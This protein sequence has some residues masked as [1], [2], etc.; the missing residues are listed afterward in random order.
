MLTFADQFAIAALGHPTRSCEMRV[1]NAAATL[2]ITLWIEIEED[3]NRF[4][5]VGAIARCVEQAHIELHVFSI[6][7]CQRL[8]GRWFVKKCLCRLSHQSLTIG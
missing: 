8:A 3:S 2:G 6:I 5:P 4:A 1:M 7:W